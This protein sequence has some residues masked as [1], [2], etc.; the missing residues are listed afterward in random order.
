MAQRSIQWRLLSERQEIVN[1]ISDL[2]GKKDG[3]VLF[4]GLWRQAYGKGT[5]RN[6]ST[7]AIKCKGFFYMHH[8]T[9][10]IAH[11]MAFVTPVLEHLLEQEITQWVHC[12]GS[13]RRPVAP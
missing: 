2:T 9:Y 7:W 13:I 10:R 1:A 11:T 8:P 4:T 6:I 12:D 3:K 5:F